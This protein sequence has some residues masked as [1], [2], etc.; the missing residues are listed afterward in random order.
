MR[1]ST[2]I[3][4]IALCCWAIASVGFADEPGG[5][6]AKHPSSVNALTERVELLESRL[7]AEH[8]SEKASNDWSE[9]IR[10]GDFPHS[11]LIPGTNVSAKLGGYV[12]G[13]VI[14]DFNAIASR[15]NFD[16]STIPT[17][18]RDG[19]NTRLHARQTRLNLDVR[20]PNDWG[21][22]RS[23]VEG[24]FFG[25]GSTFRLRHAYAELGPLL[26][27]QTWTTFTHIEAL[28]ETIDFESPVSFVL[29]R[30]GMVRWTCEP[31]DSV[32]VAFAVEDPQI[33]VTDPDNLPMVQ[34][35]GDD[36]TPL[37]DFVGRVRYTN[38]WSQFQFAS[39]VRTLGFRPEGEDIESETGYGLIWSGF[40]D[41]FDNHRLMF[42]TG[43]GEG[44]GG[45]RGKT[46]AV[47][48]PAGGL[49][50]LDVFAGNVGYRIQW[51]EQW[52]ST[53]TYSFGRL[54]N[55]IFER[56]DALHALQYLAV[57]L[58][59]NPVERID[60]GVEYL[61]G[62]REDKDGHDGEAH[63]LQFGFWYRLP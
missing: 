63:R 33:T 35:S 20:W 52:R 59:W 44:V 10:P 5:V 46:D 29:T 45:L 42:Q 49:H 55:S 4:A 16:T 54:N 18:G 24:D 57:N 1:A 2:T 7:S 25:A 11:I 43:F 30:R 21:T 60:M 53:A 48:T 15:D 12:K 19:E 39:V 56:D 23:F 38:E 14:H 36:Q 9:V 37:P 8:L 50:L 51:T 34:L 17:D 28:P 26:V 41:L 47:P 32:T 62:T 40:A 22:V 27:G 31:T 3:H 6:A 58:I 13:D 61:F